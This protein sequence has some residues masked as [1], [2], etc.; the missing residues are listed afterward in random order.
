M[1]QVNVKSNLLYNSIFQISTILVPIITLPYLSRVLRAEGLGAYSFA[2]SVAFYFY[3]FIR[4]GLNI[5][6]NRTIAYVKDDPQKL[7]KTFFEIYMFQLFMGIV[8]SIIYMGYCFLVAPN[9]HLAFVFTFMVV[10]GG[11][12]FTWTLN[13]LE[14][15]KITSLRDVLMKIATAGCI[16][17]FVK[18]ADDVWKYALI[19]NLGFLV[20]Q[21]I[22]IPVVSKR[23]HYVRPEL[24]CVFSH[25][26]P[27]VILFLPTVAVSIYKTMDKIMLGAMT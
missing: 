17:L 22:A 5:Y 7:S 21:L 16:F 8:L 27:N 10:A 13:G 26:K 18:K 23:V 2:Y 12:D 1:K 4:M 11:F 9:K 3:V 25:V 15:F 6:G 19:Y 24:K 14:E 20:S